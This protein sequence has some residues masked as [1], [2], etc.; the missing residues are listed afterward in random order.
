M[1]RDMVVELGPGRHVLIEVGGVD[2]T[3][4]I[5]GLEVNAQAAS[6][7]NVTLRAL[8]SRVRVLGNCHVE[9]VTLTLWG[10]IVV[11]LVRLRDAWREWRDEMIPGRVSSSPPKG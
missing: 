8:P 3:N 5:T 9:V 1:T 4:H 10:E 2:I 6:L 7:T 11:A